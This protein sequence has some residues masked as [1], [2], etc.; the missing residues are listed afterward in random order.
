MGQ[1]GIRWRI[2]FIVDGS[3]HVKSTSDLENSVHLILQESLS[4]TSV[5]ETEVSQVVQRTINLALMIEHV[6]KIEEK[7]KKLTEMLELKI[8]GDLFD[9]INLFDR[10]SVEAS[11][12]MLPV[13][14][15]VEASVPSLEPS[16]FLLDF[17]INIILF[18]KHDDL[19][20]TQSSILSVIVSTRHSINPSMS[21][22]FFIVFNF[23]LFLLTKLILVIVVSLPLLLRR[24]ERYQGDKC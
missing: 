1:M 22:L 7:A 5:I 23:D 3:Q 8:L 18:F 13:V 11:R 9:P 10:L 19:F 12:F 21:L 4:I 2:F 14:V 16:S 20:S 6:V 17:K 24:G 15:F